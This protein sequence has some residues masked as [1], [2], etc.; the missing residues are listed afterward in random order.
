[1]SITAEQNNK[2][3]L[4]PYH[5][6]NDSD[7]LDVFEAS[8]YFSGATELSNGVIPTSH[9]NGEQRPRVWR[10]GCPRMSLDMPNT[11]SGTNITSLENKQS[12]IINNINVNNNKEKKHKQPSSPGGKLANF[13]N[14]LFNQTSS[15]KKKS[16]SSSKI[17]STQSMKDDD[18]SPSGRRKR[19]SSISHF[20]GSNNNIDTK[21]AINTP[22]KVI[23]I[24]S[25]IMMKPAT[26][27]VTRNDV[28]GTDY[29]WLNDKLQWVDRKHRIYA[30]GYSDKLI[31]DDYKKECRVPIRSTV[32]NEL[33]DDDDDDVDEDGRRNSDSSSDLFELQN[34]NLGYDSCGLPVYETT[35]MDSIKR[36]AASVLPI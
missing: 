31:L 11:R 1:M 25:K 22:I 3:F 18:E 34:Y 5:R 16:S 28:V 23:T 30:N 10:T 9:K 14:S 21:S 15:K 33:D 19:R 24:P 27:N 2:M 32:E 7:E 36:S 26:S 13:L 12:T 6:R 8:R 4:K 29:A 17:S 35:N 20:I